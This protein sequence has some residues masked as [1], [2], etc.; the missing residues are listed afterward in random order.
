MRVPQKPR[1]GFE[2][3]LTVH[4]PGLGALLRRTL[5]TTNPIESWLSTA[6]RIA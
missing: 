1:G 2:E 6:Q 3:T 5:A 4:R